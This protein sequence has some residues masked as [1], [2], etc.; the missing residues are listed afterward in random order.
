MFDIRLSHDL[1]EVFLCNLHS[2][3]TYE[4]S[5]SI[6]MVFYVFYEPQYHNIVS[7]SSF[8]RCASQIYGFREM[9]FPN[10]FL[11]ETAL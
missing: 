6:L 2:L 9:S 10:I 5:H 4:F 7:N 11:N 3:L 1:C 8:Q